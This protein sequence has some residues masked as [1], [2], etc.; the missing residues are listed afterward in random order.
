M[1]TPPADT[2]PVTVQLTTPGTGARSA[3]A[4][5]AAVVHPVMTA[6]ARRVPLTLLLDLAEPTGPD[7]RAVLATE[8]A[9]LSWLRGLAFPAP[10]RAP[11]GVPVT[12]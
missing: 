7:S 10:S 4:G 11:A 12:G 5:V 3:D 9:D 1:V 8:T 6:L 2:Q